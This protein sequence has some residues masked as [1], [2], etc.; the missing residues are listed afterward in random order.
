MLYGLELIQLTEYHIGILKE[1]KQ[2]ESTMAGYFST[3]VQER[4][5]YLILQDILEK[6]NFRSIGL[7]LAVDTYEY[8]IWKMVKEDTIIKNI[9]V[10]NETARYIDEDF[11]PEAIII[12]NRDPESLL[13]FG[14][15]TYLKYREVNDEI[16]IW[17][18]R[19]E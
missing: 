4:D 14:E 3:R 16:S 15:E 11:F 1:Q 2:W 17:R 18:L 13:S 8:P 19:K 5:N 7:L 6:E 12:I 9:C 10:K